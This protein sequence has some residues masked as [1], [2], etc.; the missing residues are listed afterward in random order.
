MRHPALLVAAAGVALLTALAPIDG[1]AA[2]APSD[3]AE[4]TP[5]GLYLTAEEAGAMKAARGDEVLFVDVREPVEIMFTGFTHMV[6]I[7]IPFLLVDPSRWHPERPVLLMEENP[8]FAG[9]LEAA[10]DERGLDK[11][12]PVILMCRSGGDRGAPSARSLDGRGFAAVYV[13]VDGFEGVTSDADPDQPWRNVNGWKNSSWP[14]S[15]RL[16]PEKIFTRE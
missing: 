6:D 12:T 14:W 9:L 15:Y 1:R 4:Q 11:S 3:P 5:W 8:D 13:V 2:E 7:N 10:L 16:D